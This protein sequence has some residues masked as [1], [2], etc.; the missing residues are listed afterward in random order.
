MRGL[1]CRR[2]DLDAARTHTGVITMNSLRQ[3][4][5]AA[6]TALYMAT[7]AMAQTN[8]PDTS[9]WNVVGYFQQ[10]FPKQTKTNDQIDDL[11]SQF[12]TGF[13]TWDDTLNGNIGVFVLRTITRKLSAGV[14]FDYSAGRIG[15]REVVVTDLGDA[16]IE[17][18]QRYHHYI[19]LMGAVRY[20]F[21]EDGNRLVPFL[22]GAAGVAH[23]R[24]TSQLTIRNQFLD[25]NLSV[26]NSMAMPLGS[27]GAGVDLMF[28]NGFFIE[29]MGSYT[30][31]NKT[32][33]V[34][35]QGSL[36]SGDTIEANSQLTG[37]NYSIGVGKTF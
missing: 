17:F 7:P 37:P 26:E 24:D 21:R 9:N 19:D 1:L 11:N 35:A 18:E 8:A 15:G 27:V 14:Q 6:L 4:G 3:C 10:S 33:V 31:G 12:G 22:Y 16:D 30:W 25:E 34:R 20:N 5:I 36:R 28:E 2:C 29:G 32:K 23:E 13:P